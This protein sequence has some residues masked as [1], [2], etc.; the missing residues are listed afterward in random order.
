MLAAAWVP[1]AGAAAGD[2]SSWGLGHA[3]AAGA[4][5]EVMLH[6]AAAW[7]CGCVLLGSD[8]D[9]GDDGDGAASCTVC[10]MCEMLSALSQG[11]APC[12]GQ[13]LHVATRQKVRTGH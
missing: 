6:A 10:Q 4:V 5:G 9:G 1:K 12:H 8:G 11:H 3:S 7:R 13:H 2:A